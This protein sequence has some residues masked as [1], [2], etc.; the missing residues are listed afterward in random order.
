MYKTIKNIYPNLNEEVLKTFV[1]VNQKYWGNASALHKFGAVAEGLLTK[2]RNNI[3]KLLQLEGYHVLFTSCA[4][5]SN[6]LVI[7]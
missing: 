4:T 5:E 7:K 1:T 2:A 3:L 6:N